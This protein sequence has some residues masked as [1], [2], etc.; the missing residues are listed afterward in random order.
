MDLLFILSGP[1]FQNWC[2]SFCICDNGPST[3]PFKVEM[4]AL[5]FW[6]YFLCI[7]FKL[8]PPSVFCVVSLILQFSHLTCPV[9][10]LC[11]LLLF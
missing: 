11:L 1:K 5:L 4:H 8:F 6:D 10:P 2:R 3:G 7:Y 9:F